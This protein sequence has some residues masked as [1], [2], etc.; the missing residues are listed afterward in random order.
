MTVFQENNFV[1]RL[2][3][4]SSV[5]V[6]GYSDMLFYVCFYFKNKMLWKKKFTYTKR[7]QY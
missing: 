1:D 5:I 6:L 7:A 4:K 3:T 2:L